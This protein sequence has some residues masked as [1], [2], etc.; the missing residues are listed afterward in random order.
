MIDFD[1]RVRSLWKE[2]KMASVES[3]DIS[4]KEALEFLAGERLRI[5]RLSKEEAI[6]EILQ[7]NKIE[8]KIKAIESVSS[9]GLLDME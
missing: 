5:M 2:E 3:I 4:K 9:N 1:E 6:R 7:A 8:S